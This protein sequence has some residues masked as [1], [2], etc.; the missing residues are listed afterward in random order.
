MQFLEN[1]GEM[2]PEQRMTEIAMI[3]AAGVRR[4]RSIDTMLGPQESPR[5][6]DKGLDVGSPPTPPCD[7]ELT[8]GDIREGEHE[9]AHSGTS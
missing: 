4:V 6:G 9:A 3:L 8:D 5:T 1:P 7:E 2:T